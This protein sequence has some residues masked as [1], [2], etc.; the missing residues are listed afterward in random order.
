M[1]SCLIKLLILNSMPPDNFDDTVV[2]PNMGWKVL[3][4]AFA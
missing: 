3:S 2:I 4:C 1:Q